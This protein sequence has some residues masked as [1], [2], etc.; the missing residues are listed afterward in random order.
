MSIHFRY[1]HKFLD[2]LDL[3]I[4]GVQRL[5]IAEQVFGQRAA[6]GV[7]RKAAFGP[8]EVRTLQRGPE[9]D[10]G[11]RVQAPHP[12]HMGRK[13][14]QLKRADVLG[15][16]QCLGVVGRVRRDG[17]GI[18]VHARDHLGACLSVVPRKVYPGRG[19]ARTAEQVDVQ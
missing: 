4:I 9:D 14:P 16:V 19:A 8:R 11:V 2:V 10:E 13:R 17:V 15:I 5:D 18:V 7:A 1:S 6:V 12:G 3:D